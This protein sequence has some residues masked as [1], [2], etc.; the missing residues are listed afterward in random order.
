M[1]RN[2]S[3]NPI[4]RLEGHGKIEIFLNEAGEVENA[5]FQ[6]PELRGFEVF[7]KGR[8]V[9]EMPQITARLCGVCP[10]AHHLASAKAADAVYSV[11]PPT[12]AKKLRELMYMA[13]FCHSHIAHFYVL[14]APDFICG[15]EAPPTERNILGVI[16]R[17]GLKVG[18]QVIEQRSN[19]QRAQ[20]L[21]AGRATHMAWAIPGG[22]SK[23]LSES[24]RKTLVE[25]GE[26]M[27]EFASFSLKLFRE[28][29]L[30]N[31]MYVDMIRS[32]PY[33]LKVHNMGLVDR[34]D[35]VN[36]YDGTVKVCSPD[37]IEIDRYH[38]ADYLNHIAE[39]VEP[40]TYL[41]FPFLKIRG[42]KG[43]EEGDS[44]GVYSAT[45]LSRLNV[46][47]GM[48][49]P[50]A[51]EAYEEFYTTLGAKPVHSV[52]ANHWARLI[53]LIYAAE[54]W[55]ELVK[56]PE[57]TNP[58]VHTIPEAAPKEGVG[59][60]EAPRGTLTHHYVTD[61][62]GVLTSVNLIVGTT[63]NNAPISMS[64]TKAARGLISKNTEVTEG[65]LNKIEM[66]FRAYDPCMSCAT[67]SLPGQMPLQ[68]NLRELDGKVIRTIR[69]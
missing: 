14:A 55:C 4:T 11:D 51:Q 12:T 16:A 39:W 48:A 68:I 5:Y 7:C 6:V 1:K 57:I 28:V 32:D 47:S 31:S 10:A 50:S 61:E 24:D 56:D 62:K 53:E 22:V 59:C 19:A 15:P 54:R 23:A 37:G 35:R 29:V 30:G 60:V 9:E 2:I 17:A 13:H 18:G 43:F 40:Y 33:A 65:T 34:N 49:T 3:I 64:I 67:H 66:A 44:S 8:P 38:P 21:L 63:N 41:K 26:G 27:R 52:L 58:N 69:R 46:A 25:W 45:P 20:A 36:F 42:W